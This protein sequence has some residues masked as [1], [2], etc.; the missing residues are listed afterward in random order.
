MKINFKWKKENGK[1]NKQQQAK[2]NNKEKVISDRTL[3]CLDNSFSLYIHELVV[4]TK[5][6][7][8]PVW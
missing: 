5:V 3:C 6:H 7:R 8:L 2:M 4:Y 1:T